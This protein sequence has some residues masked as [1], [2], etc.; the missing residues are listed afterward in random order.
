MTDLCLNGFLVLDHFEG[1]SSLLWF[2]ILILIDFIPSIDRLSI[3]FFLA[4]FF[5]CFVR[6]VGRISR[7]TYKKG[8]AASR[9]PTSEMSPTSCIVMLS[10]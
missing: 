6:L 10:E 9:S 1:K 5:P 4:L 7:P 8:V 2:Q 3:L